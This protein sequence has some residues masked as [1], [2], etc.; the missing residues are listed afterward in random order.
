LISRFRTRGFG[1]FASIAGVLAVALL[2]W[3]FYPDVRGVTA[4]AAQLIV[5]LLIALRWGTGP[6]LLASC[7]SAVYLN[8]YYVPPTMK[9]EIR[10]AA[11]DDLVALLVYLVTAILVG[12]LSS[13]TQRRA[14][15]VQKLY[16]Q[17]RAAF[18]RESQLE[19]IRRS[20]QM[21]SALLDTVTHD[22]RTPLT[23][24]KAAA[25]ALRDI[26][27]ASQGTGN[28]LAQQQFLSIIVQQSDR[29]NHFIEGM[30]ELAKLEASDGSG[31]APAPVAVEDILSAGIARVRDGS[32]SHIFHIDCEDNLEVLVQAKAVSQAVYSLLENAVRYSPV[33]TTVSVSAN[34][35]NSDRVL[36]SVEDEGPG[37]PP[38]MRKLVF[39]KFFRV[40]SPG[41]EKP[42]GLGLGLAIARGI[43]EAHGGTIA[44]EDRRD[45]RPGT[46]FVVVLPG[47][48]R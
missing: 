13:R 16:D 23:S 36:I 22:L 21:K 30:I 11:G 47:V 9:F 7:L 32:R 44:I 25:T 1:Y 8:F 14:R 20:E 19:G 29:L 28:F 33:G 17:L 2:L 48:S 6:A 42:E 12:Q 5:V 43:T 34:R 10:L 31:P 46:R 15:E 4:A 27:D 39:D 35:A 26:T 24:I 45:G 38:A 41:Q 40:H 37:I 3:P 18:E